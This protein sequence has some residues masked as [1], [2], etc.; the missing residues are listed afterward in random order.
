MAEDLRARFP[1]RAGKVF[2]VP[3]GATEFK[4]ANGDAAAVL[5]R[6]G[7][8]PGKYVLAVGRLVPEKG[9]HDLIPAFEKAGIEQKLLIVGR[10]D[11]ADDYSRKLEAAASDAIVFAG[12]VDHAN[13]G[14]LYRH[15]SLFVLPSHHEG[16]PLSALEA[17]SMG[18]PILVSDIE[19]NR[20]LALPPQNYF[21]V[22]DIDA[23]A[24]KL[25]GDHGA[26]R[27]AADAF[28]RKYRWDEVTAA[29]ARV[30]ATVLA[31]RFRSAEAPA[32]R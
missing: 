20:D 13:L 30:Y 17:V 10:A 3:N 12:F 15:A 4:H 5:A 1:K 29:T 24:A 7:V 6:F 32:L 26:Y 25:R 18:A 22:G 16:M 11:H 14:A 2:Y 31:G 8:E 9:F 27:V 19:A 21:P 23:L 28:L